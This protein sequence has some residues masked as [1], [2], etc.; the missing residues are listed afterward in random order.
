M[1]AR[2]FFTN[3]S[4][5]QIYR[6]IYP[7]AVWPWSLCSWIYNYLCNQCLSPSIPPSVFNQ[8][9]P[10]VWYMI[11]IVVS[12][13]LCST[14]VSQCLQTSVFF[15]YIVLYIRGQCGRDRYVVGFTT[16]YAISAYHHWCEFESRSGRSVQHYVILYF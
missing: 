15:K 3:F 11:Y 2:I 14:K 12:H 4:V 13:P 5:L 16:T 9:L 10:M 6:I 7:G 1:E 8:S